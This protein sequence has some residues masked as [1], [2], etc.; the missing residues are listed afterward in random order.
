MQVIRHR[1]RSRLISSVFFMC[2]PDE[3]VIYG[4]CAVNPDPDAEGL[5]DI[6]LQSAGFGA[7][8]RDRAAGRD[9]QLQHRHFGRG[10][11]RGEGRRGHPD[12]PE[13]ETRT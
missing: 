6:A 3:V 7:G 12:R 9:D 8:V 4:D 11:R 10:G 2:L 5:A 13:R 1:A